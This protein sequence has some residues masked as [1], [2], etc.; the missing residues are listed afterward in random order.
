M[1][2]LLVPEVRQTMNELQMAEISIENL[3]LETVSQSEGV[4][5]GTAT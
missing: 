3:K 2:N 4:A 5:E 1:A